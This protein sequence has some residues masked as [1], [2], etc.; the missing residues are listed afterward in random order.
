M[1]L[2]RL[3]PHPDRL[4]KGV[5]VA[6]PVRSHPIPIRFSMEWSE[7]PWLL[8]PLRC[9]LS[10]R[11]SAIAFGRRPGVRQ[12][13]RVTESRRTIFLGLDPGPVPTAASFGMRLPAFRRAHRPRLP[14]AGR[15]LLGSLFGRPD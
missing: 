4:V 15:L 6:E 13:S 5:F 8:F 9:R 10:C 2:A 3:L 11:R 1:S 14:V 7:L 12:V